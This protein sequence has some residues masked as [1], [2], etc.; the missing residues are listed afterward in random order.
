MWLKPKAFEGLDDPM[1]Y[2]GGAHFMGLFKVGM[3]ISGTA[4]GEKASGRSMAIGAI[5]VIAIL[6]VLGLVAHFMIGYNGSLPL[7]DEIS[8]GMGKSHV[9]EIK[10][11]AKRVKTNGGELKEVSAGVYLLEDMKFRNTVFDVYLHFDGNEYLQRLEY[12]AEYDTD[13]YAAARSIACLADALHIDTLKVGEQHLSMNAGDLRQYIELHDRIEV[14]T[15]SDLTPEKSQPVSVQYVLR[16]YLNECEQ[17]EDW[18]GKVDDY[19]VREARCYRDMEIEYKTDDELLYIRL[20]YGVEPD[21]KGI[22]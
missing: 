12:V 7:L 1:S 13:T 20:S 15:Y 9:L 17:A 18:P 21:R 8:I 6:V 5:A 11:V 2:N 22:S 10:G 3:P 19:V 16:N 14:D 4:K